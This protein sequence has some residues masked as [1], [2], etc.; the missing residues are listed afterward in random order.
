L[1]RKNDPSCSCSAVYLCIGLEFRSKEIE[2]RM[3][4]L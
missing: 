4:V 2:D 1:R 3:L